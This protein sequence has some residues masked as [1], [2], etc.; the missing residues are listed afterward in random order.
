MNLRDSGL[1]VSIGLRANSTSLSQVK[2][3]GFKTFC[4]NTEPC[5][6]QSVAILTPDDTHSEIIQELGRHNTELTIYFAHGFSM[7]QNQFAEKFPQFKFVLLAPKSIASELRFRFE[8]K[9]NLTAFYSLEFTDSN[10]LSQIE[11]LSNSLGINNIYPT[12]FEEE[13]KADLFSEQSVL[14]SLIPYGINEAFNTLIQ[15]GYSKE[16]AFFECFYESKLILDTIFKMGPVE[17]FKLI[18]P[19]ALIGSQIG[20]E[21]LFDDEFKRKLN[22]LLDDIESRKFDAIIENT[23][24]DL[25]ASHVHSFWSDQELNNTYLELKGQL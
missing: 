19:N 23:D 21:L 15:R 1:E 3:I 14:C 2:A 7:V 18:S 10:T 16:I 17:F 11:D 6:N 13:T 9:E 8:T 25:M 20:K 4:I 5:P 22:S 24:I 12:K